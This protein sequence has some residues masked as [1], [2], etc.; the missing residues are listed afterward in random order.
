MRIKK[1]A[2]IS[3]IKFIMLDIF[4]IYAVF[5]NDGANHVWEL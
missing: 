4:I 2:I 5:G 1:K 3:R